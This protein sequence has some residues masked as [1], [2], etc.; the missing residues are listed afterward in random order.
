MVVG[1]RLEGNDEEDGKKCDCCCAY[2]G[3]TKAPPSK[4]SD[5]FVGSHIMLSLRTTNGWVETDFSPFFPGPSVR[6]VK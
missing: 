6:S 5:E 2:F 4:D 1:V 3:V